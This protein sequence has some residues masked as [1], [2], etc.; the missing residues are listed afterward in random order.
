MTRICAVVATVDPILRPAS[1][2]VCY[3]LLASSVRTK[4]DLVDRLRHV[5]APGRGVVHLMIAIGLGIFIDD[6]VRQ[7][8]SP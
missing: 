2:C 3:S 6:E 8:A 7:S 5:G 1:L 4:T